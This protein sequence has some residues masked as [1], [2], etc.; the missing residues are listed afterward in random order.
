MPSG[1]AA[2]FVS[3]RTTANGAGAREAGGNAAARTRA[4]VAVVI[5][6]TSRA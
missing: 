6:I 3:R 4:R 1:W 2:A 5:E